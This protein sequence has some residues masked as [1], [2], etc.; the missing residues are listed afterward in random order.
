MNDDAMKK[1][2]ESS[3]ES[4]AE[5]LEIDDPRFRRRPSEPRASR[6]DELRSRLVERIREDKR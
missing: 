5:M 6:D 3:L 4:L 2:H 1:Q